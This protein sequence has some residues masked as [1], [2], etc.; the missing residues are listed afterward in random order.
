[1]EILARPKQTWKWRLL[2]GDERPP[3]LCPK[4]L[5][6]I[7]CSHSLQ[8]GYCTFRINCFCCEKLAQAA[9]SRDKTRRKW[10]TST[11]HVVSDTNQV[12]EPEERQWGCF[13]W[14]SRGSEE[15]EGLSYSNIISHFHCTFSCWWTFPSGY[16]HSSGCIP[17][18]SSWIPFFSASF[19]A[20]KACPN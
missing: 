20:A 12:R 2:F 4:G 1:M 16:K 13:E 3:A 6:L 8:L 14:A 10:G 18:Q 15:E 9:G 19:S 11:N 5:Q 17:S 7:N